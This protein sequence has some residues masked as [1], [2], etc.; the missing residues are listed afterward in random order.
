MRS[1]LTFSNRSRVTCD[2][3]LRSLRIVGAPQACRS[4][5]VVEALHADRQPVH[6]K[7]PDVAHHGRASRLSGFASM[8]H[9]TSGSKRIESAEG[10]K[11][12]ATGRGMP[13]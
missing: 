4:T 6:A 5:C 11:Q 2:G 1:T 8:V 7:R 13:T 12:H 3:P 10:V 9:S